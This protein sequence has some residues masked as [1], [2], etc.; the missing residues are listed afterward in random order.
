M[1]GRISGSG[2]STLIPAIAGCWPWG[3][4][5][6]CCPRRQLRSCR[7]GPH[8]A[9]HFARRYRLAVEGSLLADGGPPGGAKTWPR[10]SCGQARWER[11]AGTSRVGAASSARRLREAA[12]DETNII[13]R[14]KR[15][16]PRHR[17]RVQLLT[18]VCSRAADATLFSV[19]HRTRLEGVHSACCDAAPPGRPPSSRPDPRTRRLERSRPPRPHPPPAAGK[20]EARRRDRAGKGQVVVAGR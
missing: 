11:S 9:R 19:G 13:I 17:Q 10:V 2:K 4:G 14:R 12:D 8:H 7:S 20:A 6:S 1:L 16:A 15:P 5:A 3:E 18:L